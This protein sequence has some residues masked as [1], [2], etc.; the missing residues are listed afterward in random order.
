MVR[1]HRQHHAIVADQRDEE[2]GRLGRGHRPRGREQR[3]GD[4]DRP[5]QWTHLIVWG[6]R[7]VILAEL[8][9]P[10]FSVGM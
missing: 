4:Q 1:R 6:R 2:G 8:A 7:G 10:R 3:T 5:S 9:R